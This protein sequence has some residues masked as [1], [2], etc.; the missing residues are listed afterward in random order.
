MV[1]RLFF[2]GDIINT[3]SHSSFISYELQKIIQEQDFSIC[4]FEAPI[5][6]VGTKNN[7][8]GPALTQKKETIELLKVAGFN[9]LLLANN[10]I[11]DHGEEAL[12]STLKAISNS[13][14]LTVGAGLS[15]EE[16]YKPL[17]LEMNGIKIGLINA[18]EAQFGVLDGSNLAQESGYAWINHYLIDDTIKSMN[19]MVD[20]IIV[21]SHAGL[22][23]YP[24]P[25]IEWRD[26]YKRLCDIGAD[27]II[28]SHPHVPQGF[29]IYNS[30]PIFY[31]LGNFYFD[32]PPYSNSPDYSYS[33][34]LKISKKQIGFELVYHHKENGVVRLTKDAEISFDIISLNKQLTDNKI[35]EQVYL[36]AYKN[37]TSKYLADT[38]CSVKYSNS[39]RQLIK[40]V[41]R[42][43][44]FSKRFTKKRNTLLFHLFRNETYRWVTQR[45]I[46]LKYFQ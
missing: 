26:R 31:S 42:N 4:N 14:L 3:K 36:D 39:M 38:F 19:G 5:E 27:C 12:S 24:V 44:L 13:H 7:K 2:T 32:L 45:A 25:L 23:D 34:I 35:L 30:K 1:V 15:K 46:N 33:V 29:E 41:V 8:A 21:C 40:N 11:Y 20:K 37:I 6:G 16:T 22:E 17:I 28:G 43:F 9:L 18:C 10:H